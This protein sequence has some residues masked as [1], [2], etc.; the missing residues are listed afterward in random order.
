MRT[1]Q[2][3]KIKDFG[4]EPLRNS[5]PIVG[6]CQGEGYIKGLNGNG[7]KYNKD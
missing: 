3:D 5:L 7:E 1:V 6:S 4:P 2:R